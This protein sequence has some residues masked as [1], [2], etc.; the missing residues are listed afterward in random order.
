[1]TTVRHKS[2][3]TTSAAR[4]TAHGP[5]GL[6]KSKKTVVQRLPEALGNNADRRQIRKN[7]AETEHTNTPQASFPPES[8]AAAPLKSP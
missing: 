7:L 6:R 8:K 3:I 5:A 2:L 4:H 1:M